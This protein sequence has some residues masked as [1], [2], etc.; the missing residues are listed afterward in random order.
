MRFRFSPL[1][2]LS[3]FLGAAAAAFSV[4]G[5]L[6]F[7]GA[8]SDGSF[9]LCEGFF[10][11]L[12]SAFAPASPLADGPLF[13][14][15]FSF[16]F[17]FGFS[18]AL[19][20]SAAPPL[21]LACGAGSTFGLLTPWYASHASLSASDLA[22]Y[23]RRSLGVMPC[24]LAF[25]SICTSDFLKRMSLPSTAR[26]SPAAP[27]NSPRSMPS[28]NVLS[29]ETRRSTVRR[30]DSGSSPRSIRSSSWLIFLKHSRT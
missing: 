11:G 5:F 16:G 10:G 22:S 12:M 23:G 26:S 27:N 19:L 7:A 14:S 15:F 24:H 1:P 17:G 4:F 21:P 2:L 18:A 9:F 25:A 8:S 28:P 20:L 3:F 6:I 13:T 30:R 29:A